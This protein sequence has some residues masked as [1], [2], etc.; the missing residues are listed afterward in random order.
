[1]KCPYEHAVYTRKEGAELLLV[2]VYVD[3]LI[4]TGTS[5]SVIVKFKGELIRE[6]DMTDLG[7]L[8]YYLGLE[9][10]QEKGCIE[11]KQRAYAKKVLQRA[12]LREC[13][14]VKFP[15]ELKL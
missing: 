7:K 15:M 3:D 8:S 13:N 6:F 9:V 12:G 14:A 4:M 1:M 10:E 11:I 2:G 5:V